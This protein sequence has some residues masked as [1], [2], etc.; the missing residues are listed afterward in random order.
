MSE[1][2]FNDKTKQPTDEIVSEKLDTVY[3]YWA[4]IREYV[5]DL[6][7]DITGEWK[8]YGQK[9]GWQLKTLLKKRNLFFLIPYDSFFKI[10]LIFG[11]K[12][13]AEIEKSTISD[14]IKN[15]IINAK[16]YMEGR[17]IGID[18]K[19]GEFIE[20]IKALIDIKINN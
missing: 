4:E 19:D 2:I 15:D 18:V 13:V 11:D 10:V 8:F 3:Q 17:G 16:K 12:A 14:H 9:Y 20:D 6:V 5:A 1:I 7:G